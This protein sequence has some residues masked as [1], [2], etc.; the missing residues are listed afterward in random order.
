M[1]VLLNRVYKHFKGDFYI[2]EGFAI[3]SE[4][5]AK[6]VIYR[7]L[8]GNGTLFARPYDNFIEIVDRQKYPNVKQEYR[9]ELQNIKSNRK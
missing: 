7:S 3:D 2:T 4:N 5:G 8:Y 9:F 6:L 1:E